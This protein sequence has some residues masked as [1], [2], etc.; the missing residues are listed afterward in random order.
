VGQVQ[1]FIA[2]PSALFSAITSHFWPGPL[3]VIGIARTEL[4]LEVT[5]DSG[6]IGIRLPD[7]KCVRELVQACGGSLTATSANLS[8]SLPARS[9]DEVRTYFPE[10][11]D[12]IIDDGEVTVDQPSTVLDLSTAE[13]R[14]VRE[15]AVAKIQLEEFLKRLSQ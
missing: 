15:G 7:D 6:T 4:P 3:T 9:A 14:V 10:G 5:A 8:G 11:I 12:L 13:P 1:R 2:S